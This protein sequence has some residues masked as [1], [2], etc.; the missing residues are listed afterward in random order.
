MQ[1]NNNNN[2]FFNFGIILLSLLEIS[3]LEVDSAIE[4]IENRLVNSSVTN[5]FLY[6]H[7]LTKLVPTF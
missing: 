2:K 3:S 6:F 7:P 5:L 4:N 1:N